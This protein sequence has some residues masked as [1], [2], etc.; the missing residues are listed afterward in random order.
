MLHWAISFGVM[1]LVAAVIAMS[2]APQPFGGVAHILFWLFAALYALAL[3]TGVFGRGRD[4]LYSGER[5]ITLTSCAAALL[6]LGVVW[7]KN[8]WTA[9]DA[10][11]AL[12]QGVTQLAQS[13]DGD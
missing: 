4:G 8:D 7:V 11:R 3:L 5:A 13:I 12:D 6:C 9:E 2:G 1:A 10:G